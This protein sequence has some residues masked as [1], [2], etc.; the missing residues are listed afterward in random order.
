MKR[1]LSGIQTSGAL[2]IGNY[3][4]S[5][6]NWVKLQDEYET[7]LFLADLH[8]ITTPIDPALLRKSTLE[9]AAAYIAS[10]IDPNKAVIFNQSSVPSHAE[11]GWMLGCITSMGWMNRMTQFKDKA[12]KNKE[13]ASLGL[14]SYPVLMAADILLYNADLVP[15]GEDQKQHLELTRN[16]AEDFN[17]F[18]GKKYFT[19]PEIYTL[20]KTKRIMSLRDGKNK[21][22]KSDP[23]DN[24]RINLLDTK[25]NIALKIKKA[26]SDSIKEIYYDKENRPEIANFLSI[27]ASFAEQEIDEVVKIF[28]NKTFFELKL[29]LTDL[30][31]E[32]ISPI[33]EKMNYLLENEDYLLEIIRTGTRKA[34]IVAN[35]T[36]KEVKEIFGF[37]E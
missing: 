34:N 14:Y 17:R 12:G 35:Q 3:L 33:S 4:G 29:S 11:L 8:A 10:G 30:I 1:I 19:L 20:P 28:A 27:Y 21:M 31:I 36:C 18:S 23:S 16:I 24:S 26:T 25:D 2:H 9:I 37:V 6:K 5:I 7:F 13:K 32:Y 22:S 15:V